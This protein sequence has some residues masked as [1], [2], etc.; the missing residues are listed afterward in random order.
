VSDD[1][2]DRLLTLADRDNSLSAASLPEFSRGLR[3]RARLVLDERV[4]PLEQRVADLERELAAQS[5]AVARL[6][7]DRQEL[8]RRVL[9]HLDEIADGLGWG[10]RRARETL[11]TLIVALRKELA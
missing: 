1:L 7:S 4:R 8:V 6:R 3:E 5:E 9:G 11:A 2:L 10:A